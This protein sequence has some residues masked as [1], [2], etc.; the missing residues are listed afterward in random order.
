MT[1]QAI[2]FFQIL[3][4]AGKHTAIP[5]LPSFVAFPSQ[6]SVFSQKLKIVFNQSDVHHSGGA[7][8]PAFAISQE[9]SEDLR[10]LGITWSHISRMLGV[11]RWTV[12]IIVQ[13]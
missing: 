1:Q 8:R 7:G 9:S 13:E 6:F 3:Q 12:Y 5:A 2:F 4:L 11:P 10:G